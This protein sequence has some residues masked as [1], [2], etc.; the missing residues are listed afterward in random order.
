M[1]DFVY[2]ILQIKDHF[3]CIMPVV[4][5]VRKSMFIWIKTNKYYL[6]ESEFEVIRF[7]QSNDI[8]EDGIFDNSNFIYGFKLKNEQKIIGTKRFLYKN[9]YIELIDKRRYF[10]SSYNELLLA[11]FFYLN[12]KIN[13]LLEAAVKE[14]GDEG[15]NVSISSETFFP[16]KKFSSKNFQIEYYNS[17]RK[18]LKEFI[19]E[20]LGCVDDAQFHLHYYFSYSSNNVFAGKYK[21]DYS[22]FQMLPE[23]QDFFNE[24][25]P[26]QFADFSAN[27]N[28]FAMDIESTETFDYRNI[29]QI[30]EK[31]Q[32]REISEREIIE[33]NEALYRVLEEE[34]ILI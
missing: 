34:D 5:R 30:T 9:I 14:L 1:K 25:V 18:N 6:K 10:I 17:N 7:D 13:D 21:I 24:V 29:L 27:F 16:K 4:W 20:Y 12:S 33:T 3:D 26:F 32:S 15:I 19:L 28:S 11:S 8:L 23:L 2:G 22:D 31:E